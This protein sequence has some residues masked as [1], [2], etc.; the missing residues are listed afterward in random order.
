MLRA[1]SRDVP[2]RW[3]QPAR[4]RV[5]GVD[6]Y[7][8][9]HLTLLPM[10]LGIDHPP[11]LLT[12]IDISIC[13]TSPCSIDSETAGANVKGTHYIAKWIEDTRLT[14]V[15]WEA[16]RATTP[17]CSLHQT[18][19]PRPSFWNLFITG[20]RQ[21]VFFWIVR[22]SA[23]AKLQTSSSH[24]LLGQQQAIISMARRIPGDEVRRSQDELILPQVHH[25]R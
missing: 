3:H 6:M 12:T 1:D 9:H 18:R 19:K 8:D 17:S 22:D 16:A 21:Q 4:C 2:F 14:H 15:F 7:I 11:P 10:R 5:E 20:S 13:Q 24:P 23:C 25:Q